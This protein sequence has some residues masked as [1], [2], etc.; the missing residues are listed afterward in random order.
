ME[1]IKLFKVYIWFKLFDD[2]AS[3][4]KSTRMV[5]SY[6]ISSSSIF[7]G[8]SRSLSVKDTNN[9]CITA[10]VLLPSTGLGDKQ[11]MLR[12]H[13]HLS[14]FQMKRIPLQTSLGITES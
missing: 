2:D 10:V 11:L 6:I 4:E 1:I 9:I 13:M 7:H 3:D 14:L 8:L 5:N 12:Y